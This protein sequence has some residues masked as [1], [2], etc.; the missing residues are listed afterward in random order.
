MK[1]VSAYPTFVLNINSESIVQFKYNIQSI[2]FIPDS[3][4]VVVSSNNSVL[5]H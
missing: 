4:F 1:D 2:N 3:N 5:T